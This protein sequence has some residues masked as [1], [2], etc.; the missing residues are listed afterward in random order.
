MQTTA[1]VVPRRPQVRVTGFL[2]AV[3]L[4]VGMV[5]ALVE[6]LQVKD[7]TRTID[8]I[9]DVTLPKTVKPVQPP[10]VGPMVEPQHANPIMPDFVIDDGT[11]GKDVIHLNVEPDRGGVGPADH[12]PLSVQ[13]THTIPPYPPLDVR[14]GHEGTVVLRLTISAEGRVTEAIV[15]QSSGSDG[16]DN[17]ARSWV[18]AHWRYQPAIRGG[19]AVPATST[20]GVRFNLRQ[21]G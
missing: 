10:P 2:F 9:F 21:A 8:H 17:A 18:M 15:V 6:G 5:W 1:H 11:G 4:Q 16:L 13:A 12:G 3:L 14:L 19:V 7:V 20:V